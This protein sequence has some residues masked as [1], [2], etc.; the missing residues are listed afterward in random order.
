M[1]SELLLT[2]GGVIA[3]TAMVLSGAP[4]S[5]AQEWPLPRA[6]AELTWQKIAIF[7]VCAAYEVA[8]CPVTTSPPMPDP[9]PVRM[10]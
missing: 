9:G 2:I 7:N 1:S 4:R 6:L 8:E 5:A 10:E 3:I